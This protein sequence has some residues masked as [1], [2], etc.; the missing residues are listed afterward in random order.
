M[1]TKISDVKKLIFS[2]LDLYKDKNIEGSLLLK[3]YK[4]LLPSMGENYDKMLEVDY[5]KTKKVILNDIAWSIAK[6]LEVLDES[7]IFKPGEYLETYISENVAD[8]NISSVDEFVKSLNFSDTNEVTEEVVANFI[9]D[10]Y[11]KIKKALQILRHITTSDVFK[12]DLELEVKNYNIRLEVVRE[13]L[14]NAS[15]DLHK[16]TFPH[17]PDFSIVT[18]NTSIEVASDEY[19]SFMEEIKPVIATALPVHKAHIK[20]LSKVASEVK[21]DG[22]LTKDFVTLV[23]DVIREYGDDLLS[24]EEFEFRITHIKSLLDFYVLSYEYFK[25]KYLTFLNGVQAFNLF[26]KDIVFVMEVTKNKIEELNKK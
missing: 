6:H 8:I 21:Y 24:T 7:T 12:I 9:G 16:Q 10:N 25:Y 22:D 3:K 1:D 5:L 13:F 15:S 26:F 2:L 20:I 19:G 18:N 23:G 4:E 17:L 14:N 11:G